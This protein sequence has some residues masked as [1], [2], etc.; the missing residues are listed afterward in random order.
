MKR[1]AAL[2]ALLLLGCSSSDE[3]GATCPAGALAL[4]EGCATVG[5]PEGQCGVGFASDGE[6][7]CAPILP[8]EPCARGS[9]AVPGFETCKPV[10]ST[11]CPA[12]W[13]AASAAGVEGACVV[14][15]PK[16]PSGQFAWP[17]ESTCHPLRACDTEPPAAATLFVRAAA[18]PGGDGSR[19]KPLATIQEA[20]AI[21][22]AGAVIAVAE[23]VYRE[24]LRITTPVTLRGEC[25]ERT[26]LKPATTATD[27]AITV[28]AD[29]VTLDGLA[30]LDAEVGVLV[31]GAKTAVGHLWVKGARKQGIY[32]EKGDLAATATAIEQSGRAGFYVD[33]G[34]ATLEKAVVRDSGT[35]GASAE[36]DTGGVTA[37]LTLTDVTI[38]GYRSAGVRALASTVN[39]ERVVVRDAVATTDSKLGVGIRLEPTDKPKRASTATLR[40]V[41]VVGA[42]NNGVLAL[43]SKVDAERLQVSDVRGG[44]LDVAYFGGLPSELRLVSSLVERCAGAGLRLAGSRAEISQTLVRELTPSADGLRFGEGIVALLDAPSMQPADLTVTDSAIESVRGLGVLVFGS[45][46]KLERVS[47]HGVAAHADGRFGYGVEAAP[48]IETGAR[49]SLTLIGCLVEQSTHGGVVITHSDATLDGVAVRDVQTADGRFGRGI[50]VGD[51][52]PTLDPSVVHVARSW[53]SRATEVGL[54]AGRGAV[55]VELSTFVDTQPTPAGQFGDGLAAAFG[56]RLTVTSSVIRGSARAAF[57]TFGSELSIRQTLLSCNAFDVDIERDG[58]TASTV[59]DGADNACGC[60]AARRPWGSCKAVSGGLEPVDV[61]DSSAP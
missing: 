46:A 47:V 2:L 9:F 26:Q 29:G 18:T 38:A 21:A 19:S 4:D 27:A 3:K 22:K 5:V 6:G 43:G 60:L 10:R 13:D 61:S 15:A 37:D 17:G 58:P 39:L 36:I 44:G 34:K 35:F 52:K 51:K 50:D 59:N 53:V 14:P 42:R 1:R 12:A 32:V 54:F 55:E 40:D 24:T 49:A 57:S 30:V 25:A 20:L 33:G 45:P 11:V 8:A 56:G 31:R 28:E 16:C 41:F 48:S 23:G 7:G